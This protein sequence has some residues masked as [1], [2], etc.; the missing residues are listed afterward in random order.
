MLSENADHG[1]AQ[2]LRNGFGGFDSGFP[3]VGIREAIAHALPHQVVDGEGLGEFEVFLPCAGGG[4][5]DAPLGVSK[6]GVVGI[7][8]LDG[9]GAG[10]GMGR[11]VRNVHVQHTSRVSGGK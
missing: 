10:A 11:V 1:H 8:N 3:G 6:N 7:E 4:G 9:K 5:I 2:N